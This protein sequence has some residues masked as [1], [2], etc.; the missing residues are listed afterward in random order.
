VSTSLVTIRHAAK[1]LRRAQHLVSGVAIGLRFPIV[2]G[3]R[4]RLINPCDV[5]QI[6]RRLAEHEAYPSETATRE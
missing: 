5:E 2:P 3:G 1:A 4:G 6:R